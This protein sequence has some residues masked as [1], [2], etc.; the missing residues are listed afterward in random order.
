MARSGTTPRIASLMNLLNFPKVFKTPPPFAEEGAKPLTKLLNVVDETGEN[1]NV[2]DKYENDSPERI[3]A[4][5]S[6]AKVCYRI[7]QLQMNSFLSSLPHP[8]SLFLCLDFYFLPLNNSIR[9]DRFS[10]S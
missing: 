5:N 2:I 9:E 3:K 7:L 10:C 6:K 1:V 4:L 8:C